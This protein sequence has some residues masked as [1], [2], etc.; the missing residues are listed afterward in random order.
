M[1][2]T[3]E[4]VLKVRPVQTAPMQQNTAPA[5]MVVLEAVVE[6]VEMEQ[7]ELLAATEDL[8]NL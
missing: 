5:Q 2:V 7:V 6:T 1:E 3:E 8:F 4:T